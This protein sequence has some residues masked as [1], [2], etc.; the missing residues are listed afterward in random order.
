[1]TPDGES[2]G[3]EFTSCGPDDTRRLGRRLAQACRDGTVLALDGPLGAGKT[4]LVQAA[5]EAC[6]APPGLATSPTFVLSQ[7]YSGRR[8]LIHLDAYRLADLDD[9]QEIGFDELIEEPAL[10]CIEWAERIAEA[11]PSERTL[12]VRLEPVDE[13]QRLVHLSSDSVELREIAQR[14]ATQFQID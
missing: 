5:A 2:T 10:V 1:M 6:G 9:L 7:E 12:H 3:G 8:R 14:L 4:L 13:L 11:L